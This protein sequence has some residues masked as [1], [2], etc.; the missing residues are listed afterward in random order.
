[1]PRGGARPGAGRKKGVP[2]KVTTET[3][4]AFRLLIEGEHENLK[5]AL[6]EVR[7]GIEIEKQVPGIGPDGKPTVQTVVG[8]LNADPKGY[9][10]TIAKLAKFCLPE[11]GRLEH[12][13]EGGAP[14][15]VV[16]TKYSQEDE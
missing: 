3:R 15:Q 7:F 12:T 13:G 10:D 14:I 11:L 8:R 5:A 2:N 6:D 9:L 1:M 16:I 4:E